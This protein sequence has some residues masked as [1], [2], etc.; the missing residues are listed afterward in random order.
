MSFDSSE[1]LS[2]SNPNDSGNS[3]DSS[4]REKDDDDGPPPAISKTK[5]L[6]RS[7]FLYEQLGAPTILHLH[8]PIDCSENKE[9]DYNLA[10]ME[11]TPQVNESHHTLQPWRNTLNDLDPKQIHR[12]A[13]NIVQLT[14]NSDRARLMHYFH[15]SLGRSILPEGYR[16]QMHDYDTDS[17]YLKFGRN[18]GSG[19]EAKGEAV[20]VEETEAEKEKETKAEAEAEAEDRTG[21]IRMETTPLQESRIKMKYSMQRMHASPRAGYCAPF[22]LGGIEWCMGGDTMTHDD[23][24]DGDDDDDDDNDDDDAT[25]T[26]TATATGTKEV[27]KDRPNLQDNPLHYG[28]CLELLPCTCNAC[29]RNYGTTGTRINRQDGLHRNESQNISNNFLLYPRGQSLCLSAIRLPHTQSAGTVDTDLGEIP[30]RTD[31]QID[32]GGRILQVQ[33]CFDTNDPSTIPT[34]TLSIVRTPKDCVLVSCEAQHEY[35][36][37]KCTGRYKMNRIATVDLSDG[38]GNSLEPIYVAAK[39][40]NSTLYGGQGPIFATLSKNTAETVLG[41]AGP[42]TIHY[43]NCDINNFANMKTKRHEI[44]NLAS[45]SQIQ[46]SAMHPMV[47]WSAARSK[48]QHKLYLGKGYFR[49]PT[50]GYGHSLHSI[51]LRS[52]RGSFVWSPSDDEFVCTGIHSIDG[53]LTDNERPHS[54]YVSS[55]SKLYHVDARM[56][57]R[58]ICTWAL[59]GMCNDD[60]TMNSPSGI[61]G[62]GMLLTRPQQ[63]LNR[64]DTF[65]LPILGASKE[66]KSFGLH[67]YQHPEKLGNFQTKTL[68]RMAHKGLDPMR[69]IATSSFFPQPNVSE[70]A[71]TTGIAAFY[72]PAPSVF[73]DID[74]LGYDENPGLALCVI[75]STSRGHLYSHTMLACREGQE[76]KARIVHGGPLGSVA[77]PNVNMNGDVFRGTSPGALS[78]THHELKWSLSNTYPSPSDCITKPTAIPK[79]QYCKLPPIETYG[80]KMR[81]SEHNLTKLRH[82]QPDKYIGSSSAKPPLHRPIIT[83]FPNTRKERARSR[84]KRR[85]TVKK[86][87]E[88]LRNIISKLRES[89]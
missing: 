13:E 56:P 89:K 60:Q 23:G 24:D 58:T 37:I 25:A 83:Y 50:I 21:A 86:P 80:D 16:R 30:S 42:T 20:A 88:N 65:D 69:N 49:R 12:Y 85:Y 3:S 76:T 46:F 33:S 41:E 28:N 34:K 75:S 79:S 53:M 26:A 39:K 77:I 5:E 11:H 43:I 52:N 73:N 82:P 15:D 70:N 57:A 78:G 10:A 54:I 72:A 19:I 51:D 59:P 64:T 27:G 62:C 45:I 47:L 18:L 55:S 2:S 67:L 6:P 1:S 29:S 31:S 87:S 38:R 66:P 35:Y 14:Q 36:A 68:E 7:R 9:E 63:N 48:S 4:S 71:F 17:Q 22:H 61:Y 8:Q 81:I 74:S 44:G 32:V 40:H 84:K